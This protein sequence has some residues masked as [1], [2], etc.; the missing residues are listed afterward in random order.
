MPKNDDESYRRELP[1]VRMCPACEGSGKHVIEEID[2]SYK[3]G[4]CAWC[5]DGKMSPDQW[6]WW[7]KYGQ[8]IPPPK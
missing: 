3:T 8:T 5:D 1:T 2:G 7:S 4:L 6:I